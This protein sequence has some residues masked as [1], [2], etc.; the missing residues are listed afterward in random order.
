MELGELRTK[1]PLDNLVSIP[2]SEGTKVEQARAFAEVAMQVE[3]AKKYPRNMD[4]VFR[5]IEE[6][7]ERSRGLL[8]K[9]KWKPFRR[10]NQLIHGYTIQFARA[11]AGCVGNFRYAYR[12][13]SRGDKQSEMLIYAWD[14]E[15]NNI[16]D[17]IIIIPHTRDKTDYNTT[18]QYK[19]AI[20]HERDIYENNANFASR[21]LREC[22]L[23][24]LP[25][26]ALKK[27]EETVERLLSEAFPVEKL[28]EYINKA[29][30][31]FKKMGV[32][33]KAL[34]KERGNRPPETWTRNDVVTL[35]GYAEDIKSGNCG[36]SDI[37]ELDNK[38]E[39]PKKQAK[40]KPKTR[41][42]NEQK[43]S[44]EPL[45]AIDYVAR[46][47]EL[48]SD[49]IFNDAISALNLEKAEYDEICANNFQNAAKIWVQRIE[50]W[51]AP[52]IMEK[53]LTQEEADGDTEF[54]EQ[55]IEEVPNEEGLH[56]KG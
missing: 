16:Q 53:P 38:K 28:Q 37:F 21:R 52:A 15:I 6:T 36:I 23:G 17:R 18:R 3:L 8:L 42:K 55:Q 4:V 20:I 1:T 41:K 35:K 46:L 54:F 14:M 2:S 30:E 9:S 32:S 31:S 13:L 29:I 56:E 10:G 48:W 27:G 25:V 44:G 26:S 11:I 24:V 39:Y 40:E 5:R 47:Q 7:F 43:E 19:E 12:E 50:A 49:A 22:I 45:D 51:E 33:R 34:I